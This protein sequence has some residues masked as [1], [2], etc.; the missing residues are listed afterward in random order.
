MRSATSAATSSRQDD[1][2]SHQPHHGR[3]EPR[4][5]P[6][7]P[8]SPPPTCPPAR[9]AASPTTVVSSHA[10]LGGAPQVHRRRAS[11]PKAKGIRASQPQI[12]RG[13]DPGLPGV[14]EPVEVR[15][16]G[17]HGGLHRM[18]P[19][20]ICPARTAAGATAA[21][22]AVQLLVGQQPPLRWLGRHWPDRTRPFNSVFTS[23]APCPSLSW[24]SMASGR[25]RSGGHEVSSSPHLSSA[26]SSARRF[27]SHARPLRRRAAG[28]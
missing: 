14:Q 28:P 11:V 23:P 9:A 24:M 6:D 25:C 13:R 18:V 26:P 20:L 17:G 19:V 22:A 12:M 1:G 5:G 8:Q 15:R 3:H 10:D 21:G 16:Y 7:R 2:P 4:R 27:R